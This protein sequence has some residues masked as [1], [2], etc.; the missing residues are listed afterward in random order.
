MKN[1]TEN[2]NTSRE[3]ALEVLT[4][5]EKTNAY[6]NIQLNQSILKSNLTK[7]D[8]NFATEIIYGTI[9]RLNTIDW[10]IN[11]FLKSN[12]KDLEI[13][14]KNLLRLSVYQIMYLDRVPSHAIVNEAVELAKKHGH[15]GISSMVNGVLRNIIRNKDNLLTIDNLNEDDRISL[16]LSH[17]KWIVKRFIDDYGLS[18][19]KEICSGNNVAPYN[20]IRVN[21]LKISRQGMLDLLKKTF[22]ENANINPSPLST[23]GIRIKGEGNLASTKWYKDG[24]FTVQDESSMLVVDVLDPKPNMTVLDATAAP[25]GKT[26]QIAERMQNKGRIIASDIHKHKIKLIDEHQKRLGINIIET[27]VIDARKLSEKYEKIFD[28]ILLDVPCSGLGVIR[29]KPELKWT[30]SELD[31]VNLTKLQENILTNASSLLRSGGVLVYSTCTMTMEENQNMIN[32]FLNKN[33]D[34]YLD[35]SLSSYL[36]DIVNRKVGATAGSVQILP[37]YFCTDGFFICRMIKL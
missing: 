17:P 19:A 28:C 27:V 34:F 8:I 3:L 21:T 2:I 15:K 37:H 31:I 5:V 16:E 35:K 9:Q 32:E 24:Y 26:T 25:G 14:V 13:W 11:R 22:P 18:E 33:H 10:V 6:S 1:H 29:R 12:I 20:S 36:P 23:Q 30:K 4:K 7:L